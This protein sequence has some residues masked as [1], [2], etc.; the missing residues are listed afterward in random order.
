MRK[1]KNIVLS[2]LLVTV[3]AIGLSATVFAAT[4]A[5][6]YMNCDEAYVRRYAPEFGIPY[7]QAYASYSGYGLDYAFRAYVWLNANNS[8]A[9]WGYGYPS[10]SSS[11]ASV[12]YEP[13]YPEYTYTWD[14]G[15]EDVPDF[16]G[17]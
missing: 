17:K 13:C 2:L 14:H 9:Q 15:T 8:G 1:I 6:I 10:W 5:A 12:I 3:I 4:D 16:D 11:G 7:L